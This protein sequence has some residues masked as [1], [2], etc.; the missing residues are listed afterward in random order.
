MC[1]F[2]QYLGYGTLFRTGRASEFCLKYMDPLYIGVDED[3][4]VLYFRFDP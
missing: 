4:E 1:S 3:L 2:V